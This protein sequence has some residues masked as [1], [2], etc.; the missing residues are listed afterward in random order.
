MGIKKAGGRTIGVVGS[1]VLESI[2][3]YGAGDRG[4]ARRLS[5][6]SPKYFGPC[7]VREGVIA[8]IGIFLVLRSRSAAD[9][10]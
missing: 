8:G 1:S 6:S 10:A 9:P 2:L 3:V 4:A 7:G 5:T